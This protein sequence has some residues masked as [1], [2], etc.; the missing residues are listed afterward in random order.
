MSGHSAVVRVWPLLPG[1]IRVLTRQKEGKV[2]ISLILFY[3][4]LECPFGLRLH[5]KAEAMCRLRGSVVRIC[6]NDCALSGVF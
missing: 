4:I 2:I 1:G 5:I 3:F 6:V